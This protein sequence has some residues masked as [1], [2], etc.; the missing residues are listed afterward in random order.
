MSNYS[1]PDAS[2][3]RTYSGIDSEIITQ[4]NKQVLISNIEITV[5][6]NTREALL[7]TAKQ[8]VKSPDSYDP[9]RTFATADNLAVQ[10]IINH[11]SKN[12]GVPGFF[13][14]EFP[15]IFPDIP[16]KF[17][18][19]LKDLRMTREY[20]KKKAS[21][22]KKFPHPEYA[23]TI[24]Q[25]LETRYHGGYKVD[26]ITMLPGF[27]LWTPERA[28]IFTKSV[29]GRDLRSLSQPELTELHR[30]LTVIS[31]DEENFRQCLEYLWKRYPIK[32]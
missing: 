22:P 20:C 15:S 16:P 1:I 32:S 13:V 12:G 3:F 19:H 10:Y 18:K 2:K 6:R 31:C 5:G 26:A 25:T 21:D 24:V 17:W 9:D 23:D 14:R 27:G 11:T 7:E 29:K 28:E 8:I 30:L 4:Y